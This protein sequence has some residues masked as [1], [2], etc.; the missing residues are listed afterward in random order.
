MKYNVV[1]SAEFTYPDLWDYPSAAQTVD[2]FG[3]RGGFAAFQLL[4]GGCESDSVCV[5]ISGLPAGTEAE[6]Y[7]LVPVYVE[8]NHLLEPEQFEPHFPERIA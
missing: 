4:L 8:R 2:V 3:T 1:S 6:L 7:T 5:S